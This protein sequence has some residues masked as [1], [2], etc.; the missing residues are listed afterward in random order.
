[1]IGYFGNGT[2]YFGGNGAGP[3]ESRL[4]GADV[5]SGEFGKDWVFAQANIDDY[6]S[7]AFWNFRLFIED[8][9]QGI[10]NPKFALQML[11]DAVEALNVVVPALPDPVGTRP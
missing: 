2:A 5:A 4:S 3:I 8:R 1:M 11:Y 7:Y 9:S 6:E 10:H